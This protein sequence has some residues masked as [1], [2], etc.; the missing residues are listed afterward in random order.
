MF[1]S[2]LLLCLL[3]QSIN[4]VLYA[5]TVIVTDDS[6]Y[7]SGSSTA[8]LD[9]NSTTKGF[10]GPRVTNAQKKAIA[11]PTAGL[12]VYQTDSITGYYLWN[13]AKWE[14]LVSEIGGLTT[15]TKTSN[16]SLSK[17]ETFVL[18]SNNITITLPEISTSDNGLSIVVKNIGTY[19]DLVKVIGHDS[20]TIDG[21]KSAQ[22]LTRW[23][24]KTFVAN[25]GTWLIKNK[26]LSSRENILEVAPSSSWT[27]I[28]QAVAFLNMHMSAPSM[29]RLASGDYPISNT[30]TINLPYALTIAGIN[31]GAVRINANTGLAGKPMFNCSSETYFRMLRFETSPLPGYGNAVN[32]DAIWISG[33]SKKY[34]DIHECRFDGF[35]KIIKQLNHSELWV[36]NCYLLN[37]KAAGIELDAG[38][39][40]GLVFRVS[41]T[42]FT[43]NRISVN[44]LSGVNATVSIT[45]GGAYTS[46]PTDVVVNYVPTSFVTMTAVTLMNMYWNGI[47]KFTNGFDFSRQDGRDAAAYI[48]LNVNES[49]HNPSCFISV[50]DNVL[51][52]NL[53]TANVLYKANWVNTDSI[54]TLMGING[55]RITFLSPHKRDMIV[56]ITGNMR[57]FFRKS[58]IT[59]GLVKNGNTSVLYGTT[60]IYIPTILDPFQ[61]GTNIYLKDV[62]KDDYFELFCK[63]NSA[64]DV[65]IIK[66]VQWLTEAK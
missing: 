31:F 65:I 52:T 15:A 44:L 20:A 53:T 19:T 10:L 14:R 23:Q 28:D 2:K 26:D 42:K 13:N 64:S 7:I 30:I 8:V 25:D 9:V 45:N 55:N 38:T 18:A 35:N 33:S 36:F 16:A 63:S 34:Y 48:Q 17:S 50:T 43:N 39:L 22:N 5:Q 27:N 46:N 24:S 4:A 12:L 56:Y 37:A 49:D 57:N 21:A 29:I 3:F 62:N 40:S 54:T 66:D 61:F 11:A 51:N 41:A 1:K 6:T 58:E 59:I 47:G 32:E 60:T